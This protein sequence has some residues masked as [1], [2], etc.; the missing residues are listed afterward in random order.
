MNLDEQAREAW[1]MVGE[2]RVALDFESAQIFNAV[3]CTAHTWGERGWQASAE[4][5][6]VQLYEGMSAPYCDGAG[7][8]LVGFHAP[9]LEETMPENSSQEDIP[10]ALEALSQD[11]FTSWAWAP[12][13]QLAVSTYWFEGERVNAPVAQKVEERWVALEGLEADEGVSLY[14]QG[15]QMMACTPSAV[16][17]YERPGYRRVWSSSQ[18]CPV[19]WSAP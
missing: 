16:H 2:E 15:T 3:L 18:G 8:E 10:E 11:E 13:Y 14:F 17:L 1:M 7:A 5:Q 4:P 9:G 19:F 12:D 6:V